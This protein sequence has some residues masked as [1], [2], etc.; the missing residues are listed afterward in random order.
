MIK[1]IYLCSSGFC[2]DASIGVSKKVESQVKAF[3]SYK[4][5]KCQLWNE[6]KVKNHKILRRLPFYPEFGLS[7]FEHIK[8]CLEDLQFVYIR[9]S[10]I[11]YGF[12]QLIKKIKE[13]NN[14]ILI[15]LEIPTYPYQNE[16]KTLLGFP[17][18]L[19]EKFNLFKLKKYIDYIVIP[20]TE[21]SEVYDIPVIPIANGID[22]NVIKSGNTNNT[23]KNNITF[24]L[25]AQIM[26]HHRI[27]VL[28]EG[29]R[30]YCSLVQRK[31]IKLYIVGNATD[32]NEFT[33]LKS[34]IAKYHLENIIEFT[35]AKSGEELDY[36][37]DIA[38]IGIGTLFSSDI[39]T[40]ALKHREYCAKGLPFVYGG[41]DPIF[42]GKQFCKKMNIRDEIDI[43]QIVSFYMNLINKNS[44][45]EII[46]NM[47]NFAREY[48]IW[49]K[50]MEKVFE[51]IVNNT[52]IS[53]DK[54][55]LKRGL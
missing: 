45:T 38:D 12:I 31:N 22:S 39:Y 10:V 6:N 16:Y 49:E 20:G 25:V 42:E 36:Y 43:E 11:D 28:I 2:M 37:Y 47:Q 33:R 32:Y 7:Y 5:I 54:K 51:N 14:R 1:G 50:T 26:R 17:Y 52:E 34:L 18:L 21:F 48:L 29:V 53:E 24:L 8:E 27:D 4:N 13:K 40:N 23:D 9:K 35:G 55:R 15:Y 30:R 3:N 19:K 41:C 46:K 44:K